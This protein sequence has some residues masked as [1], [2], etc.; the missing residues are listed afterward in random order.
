MPVLPLSDAFSPLEV[1]SVVQA[2]DDM[3]RL[4]VVRQPM[5]PGMLAP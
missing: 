3:H 4:G 2:L 1:A 5:R